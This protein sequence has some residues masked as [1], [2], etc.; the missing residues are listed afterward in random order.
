MPSEYLV[1][2]ICQ[3]TRRLFFPARPVLRRDDLHHAR[4]RRLIRRARHRR[5]RRTRL[6][7]DRPA[8]H[9]AALH[10]ARL[11]SSHRA[12]A[13]IVD[14]LIARDARR[15]RSVRLAT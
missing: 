5:R 8:R 6:L 1:R 2:R 9:R 11:N 12:R 3:L 7:P 15:P 4:S 10:R 13:L 14:A